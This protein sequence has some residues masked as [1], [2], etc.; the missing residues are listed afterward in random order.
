M[1]VRVRVGVEF[2]DAC[3]M[4]GADDQHPRL[5]SGQSHN[6]RISMSFRWLCHWRK[7]QRNGLTSVCLSACPSGDRWVTGLEF[8]EW[9]RWYTAPSRSQGTQKAVRRG[10][11]VCRGDA[12]GA[13]SEPAAAIVGYLSGR[14]RYVLTVMAWFDLQACLLSSNIA[15]ANMQSL[16]R[17]NFSATYLF[18]TTLQ[19]WMLI[20]LTVCIM[21]R[22]NY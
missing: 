18:K 22:W 13:L 16:N 5:L 7:P 10:T 19:K 21:F 4:G 3:P 1:L 8:Q 15:I 14:R 11:T 12:N 17:A 9:R 20:N 6:R 2:G